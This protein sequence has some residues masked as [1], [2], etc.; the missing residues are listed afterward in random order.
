MSA[1]ST[2]SQ[3]RQP[4]GGG[5]DRISNQKNKTRHGRE[6]EQGSQGQEKGRIGEVDSPGIVEN[7]HRAAGRASTGW[8][9]NI[10][11]SLRRFAKTSKRFA[12]ASFYARKTSLGQN[13][14]AIHQRPY[15]RHYQAC[16]TQRRKPP[17][18]SCGANRKLL[19]AN[20]AMIDT[21]QPSA[22]IGADQGPATHA[23]ADG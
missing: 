2:R 23:H 20:V 19:Q 5:V 13:H 4:C 8:R 22:A 9:N 18:R 16:S 10:G 15:R 7:L 6:I 14:Q 1:K 12:A 17:I 21:F 11:D 3:W